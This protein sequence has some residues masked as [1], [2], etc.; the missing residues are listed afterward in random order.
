MRWTSWMTVI[1]S[2]RETCGSNSTAPDYKFC[3]GLVVTGCNNLVRSCNFIVQQN[4]FECVAIIYL[5][6]WGV[7]VY[8][9]SWPKASIW[10]WPSVFQA[11]FTKT[12]LDPSSVCCGGDIW[13]RE[14]IFRNQFLLMGG[15]HGNIHGQSPGIYLL[16]IY[17]KHRYVCC[18][19]LH[20][21]TSPAARR[22][23][24]GNLSSNWLTRS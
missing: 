4:S 15:R 2:D 7:I 6:N 23:P 20:L 8:N 1:C 24:S 16:T 14:G 17:C 10:K 12:F 3:C 18:K 5:K 9:V 11:S 19:T 13:P 22:L 21:S